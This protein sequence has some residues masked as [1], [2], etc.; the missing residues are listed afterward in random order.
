MQLEL[1]PDLSEDE[2]VLLRSNLD[3]N[4]EPYAGPRNTIELGY[5]IR[6]ASGDLV[7]GLIGVCLWQWLHIN[8]IWVADERRGQGLGTKLL[9]AA[10][11][12]AKEHC[13]E[14]ALLHTFS[15]QARPFYE[16]HGYTVVG[17]TKD[18]PKGHSQYTMIKQLE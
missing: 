8:V 2:S 4:N 18:F 17:E 16:K 13:M 15:F 9:L 3:L 11:N 12:E 14:F 10:E 5:A 7:A 1:T 6:D